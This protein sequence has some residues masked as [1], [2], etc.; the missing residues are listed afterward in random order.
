MGQ[1]CRK[2]IQVLAPKM[3]FANPILFP[4]LSCRC[5]GALPSEADKAPGA[6]LSRLQAALQARGRA[7]AGKGAQKER[8]RRLR[9]V[10]QDRG[11]SRK[12]DSAEPRCQVHSR[13]VDPCQSLKIGASPLSL[14]CQGGC[15]EGNDRAVSRAAEQDHVQ[16]RP[17]PESGSGPAERPLSTPR[18]L[19]TI[20]G[21]NNKGSSLVDR[22]L[23]LPGRAKWPVRA[24]AAGPRRPTL[25]TSEVVA[26]NAFR[27]GWR[28]L[29][30]AGSCTWRRPSRQ[31]EAP[32]PRCSAH[33][34]K[35]AVVLAADGKS[36]GMHTVGRNSSR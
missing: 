6:C 2:T 11:T 10:V 22:E 4:P 14:F 9:R 23:D 16:P 12:D 35:G 18:L 25:P 7:A 15:E 34:R 20:H 1:K 8:D 26:E 32:S 33:E 13:A 30:C 19:Q 3:P 31:Q 21:E 29:G 27:R 28:A 24:V 5:L 17:N 36:E